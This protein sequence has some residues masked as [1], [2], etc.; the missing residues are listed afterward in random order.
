MWLLVRFCVGDRCGRSPRR[1]RRRV[2]A[3]RSNL[4]SPGRRHAGRLQGGERA[5]WLAAQ[6]A[7]LPP[8]E[9][10]HIV[11]TLPHALKALLRINP[12]RLHALLFRAASA[13][14]NRSPGLPPPRRRA[15]RQPRCLH[16][17]RQN[18]VTGSISRGP[19]P[20]AGA[21]SAP[22]RTPS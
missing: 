2:R 19:A 13:S 5:K 10:F 17:W 7:A 8:A 12:R 21:S 6:Q 3:L 14:C 20:P 18:L 15:R 1:R 16:T 11:F 22:G 4:P 9:Y